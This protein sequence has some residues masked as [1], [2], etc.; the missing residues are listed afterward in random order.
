MTYGNLNDK[1]ETAHMV[2]VVFQILNLIAIL[3]AMLL[4]AVIQAPARFDLFKRSVTLIVSLSRWLAVSL[5][6]CHTASLSRCLAG[7]LVHCF[8]VSLSYCFT[9]SL[10]Y[11]LTVSLS[12][13]LA[14][15]LTHCLVNS[16]C[17][18]GRNL[19]CRYFTTVKSCC[20]T[21]SLSLL[22]VTTL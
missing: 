2:S 18:N 4:F 10:S 15:L 8:T 14:V 1:S 19:A 20:L 22:V 7:L 11:C 9:V 16:T 13:S 5:C 6:R 3:F 17:S 12:C 21:V